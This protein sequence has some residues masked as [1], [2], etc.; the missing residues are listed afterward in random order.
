M[1][2]RSVK[3]RSSFHESGQASTRAGLCNQCGGGSGVRL[4]GGY[5]PQIQSARPPCERNGTSANPRHLISNDPRSAWHVIRCVGKSRKANSSLV[6]LGIIGTHCH[7]TQQPW[8]RQPASNRFTTWY[9]RVQA[10]LSRSLLRLALDEQQF[11]SLA[12]VK[13]SASIVSHRGISVPCSLWGSQPQI[14]LS[15][16]VRLR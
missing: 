3:L 15:A 13:Q 5:E 10:V 6:G 4:A 7:F 2:L 1:T 8:P 9:C 12:I 11:T 14:E 16:V